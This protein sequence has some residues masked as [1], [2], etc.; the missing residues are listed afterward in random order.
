MK[1]SRGRLE[2]YPRL[3]AYQIPED[4]SY[5]AIASGI[6]EL[7]RII[8]GGLE[9]GTTCLIVGPSGV[10]KST[11][12]TAFSATAAGAGGHVAIFL[13]DERPE[14][15]IL[16]SEGLGVPIRAHV[17]AGNLLLRQVDPG[18]IAPGEFA[19]Q[20][21]E[22][23]ERRGTK[24][25]IIDSIIGYF[26]A[27]GASDVLVTQL[28]EL[29]TYCTRRGILTIMCGSQDGFMSI[30]TQGGVDVSYLSD[31]ILVLGYF[32]A[33]GA[34]R[35][36][37]AAVKKKVGQHDSFIHE[38]FF[39]A[40]GIRVGEEPLRQFRNLLIPDALPPGDRPAGGEAGGCR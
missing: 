22:L 34:I 26:L 40:G 24:L 2:V 31:S 1:I 14:T 29:I 39:A 8:G 20:V 33:E 23:V 18:D 38:L 17:E 32:E 6:G 30:G 21:R 36:C 5:R 19:H 25:V 10:G 9:E 28:H 35:R 27:M 37:I 4:R 11:L 13:F 16:R 7:D 15:Y 3:G 12:A